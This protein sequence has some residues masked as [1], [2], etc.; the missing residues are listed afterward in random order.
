M[1][2]RHAPEQP[3]S[4]SHRLL[5]FFQTEFF[6]NLVSFKDPIVVFFNN[7]Q[8]VSLDWTTG[9]LEMSF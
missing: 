7:E 6:F 8:N 1:T 9:F 5:N 2:N 3:S 4:S